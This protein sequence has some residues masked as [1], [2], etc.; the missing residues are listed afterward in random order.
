MIKWK[1][2]AELTFIDL[3][4]RNEQLPRFSNY[5]LSHT[6]KLYVEEMCLESMRWHP[7][8]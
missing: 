6:E 4:Q 3:S 2:T 5:V 1:S 7:A 8:V